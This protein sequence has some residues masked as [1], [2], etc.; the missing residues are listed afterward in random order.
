MVSPPLTTTRLATVEAGYVATELPW[1]RGPAA[2]ELSS[3]FVGR[4]STGPVVNIA[5]TW[6]QIVCSDFRWLDG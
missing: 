3:T 5:P 2:T 6:A 1:G 4:E